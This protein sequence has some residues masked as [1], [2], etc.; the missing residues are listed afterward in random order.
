L[1]AGLVDEV[2]VDL[3]PVVFGTGVRFFG[4]FGG[5]PALLGDPRIVAGDRVTH[6]RFEVRK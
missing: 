3:V 2:Q 4:A 5:P 6:L 1:A